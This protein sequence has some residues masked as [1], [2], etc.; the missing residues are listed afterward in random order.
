M[1]PATFS[2]LSISA[3]FSSI[4]DIL[5]KTTADVVLV[6]GNVQSIMGMPDFDL[7]QITFSAEDTH[8]VQDFPRDQALSRNVITTAQTN[9]NTPDAEQA[10]SIS[11]AIG[12]CNTWNAYLPGL[13]LSL[14]E[15]KIDVFTQGMLN[16]QKHIDDDL[17]ARVDAHITAIDEYKTAAETAVKALSVDQGVFRKYFDTSGAPLDVE[18]DVNEIQNKMASDNATTARGASV[19][20]LGV[21]IITLVI[22]AKIFSEGE[23][24]EEAPDDDAGDKLIDYSVDIIKD[25]IKEQSEASI[26]WSANFAKYRALI[27]KLEYDKQIYVAVSHFVSKMTFLIEYLEESEADLTDINQQWKALAS[28]LASISSEV[29][30]YDGSDTSA[31][32]ADLTTLNDSLV[33]LKGQ[34]LTLQGLGKV[35]VVNFK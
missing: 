32:V 4:N 9:Q 19:Q 28:L 33:A 17:V 2:A 20:G 13:L 18:K 27:E 29:T 31:F 16:L 34:L 6:E 25:D 15:S 14:Q 24:G 21:L 3:I 30:R 5:V 26:D 23:D 11:S 35:Q 10:L 8:I 1:N 7:T 22:V 12:F